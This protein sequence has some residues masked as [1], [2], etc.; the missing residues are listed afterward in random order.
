[1]CISTCAFIIYVLFYCLGGWL[2]LQPLV[3]MQLTRKHIYEPWHMPHYCTSVP[4][5]SSTH[6]PHPWQPGLSDAANELIW[7]T[8]GWIN[9]V[10]SV[11]IL[12]GIC[13]LVGAFSNEIKTCSNCQETTSLVVYKS[14][15]FWPLNWFWRVRVTEKMAKAI[16]S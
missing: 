11:V 3:Q 9:P 5:C 8:R 16:K 7:P 14:N 12:P 15:N 1:M 4:R 13:R 10:K 2:H 6:S